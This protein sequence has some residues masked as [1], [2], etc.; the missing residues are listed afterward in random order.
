MTSTA[1][2]EETPEG[3]EIEAK[4]GNE[5]K[6]IRKKLS[7]ADIR[8]KMEEAQKEANE[9]KVSAP[10]KIKTTNSVKSL[11]NKFGGSV[12]A[13]KQEKEENQTI[14]ETLIGKLKV[15][16][17]VPSSCVKPEVIKFAKIGTQQSS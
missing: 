6:V 5:K 4:E 12:A 16:S 1:P 17:S 8:K 9:T 7:V 15:A 3:V 13:K 2:I 10:K 14:T 11:I